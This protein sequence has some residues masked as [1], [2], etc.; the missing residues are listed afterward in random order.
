MVVVSWYVITFIV[1]LSFAN[2][3]ERNLV[4]QFPIAK[5][6]RSLV[7]SAPIHSNFM[8]PFLFP[9]LYKCLETTIDPKYYF[10]SQSG[11]DKWLWRNIFQHF[12]A[13]ETIGG[14]FLEIGGLDGIHL[15]NSYFFEKK[16]DWRGI[17]IEGHPANN[18]RKSQGQRGNAAIFTVAVCET[19]D[20]SPGNLTFSTNGGAT[21]AALKHVASDFRNSYHKGDTGGLTVSCIPIQSIIDSTGLLDIDLFSL[22]VEGAELVV[23]ETINFAVT[24]IR[25][26]VIELDGSNEAKDEQVRKLVLAQGFTTMK[27]RIREECGYKLRGCTKNEVFINPN[28]VTKKSSRKPKDYYHFG[29]GVKC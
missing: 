22:D 5:N 13:N 12:P 9:N 20:N 6:G 18:I 24:N 2:G 4:D 8:A 11:E 15:S 28:F 26:L 17:L 16:L 29:T 1:I 19:V 7:E 25:V 10:K 23:L 14:T 3:D 21:G 27:D